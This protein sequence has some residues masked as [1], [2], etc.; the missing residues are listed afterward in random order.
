MTILQHD[1]AVIPWA[2]RVLDGP[3]VRA[4]WGA[5]QDDLVTL[6]PLPGAM[7]GSISFG[8]DV[9]ASG[10]CCPSGSCCASGSCCPSGSIACV[11]VDEDTTGAVRDRR[12][13]RFEKRL[14][15]VPV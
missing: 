9:A 1:V 8:N 11:N 2:M 3:L 6:A 4:H 10:A 7:A 12:S 14:W 15:P 5:A 13:R